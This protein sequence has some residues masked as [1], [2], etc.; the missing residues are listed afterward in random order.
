M[1][2]DIRSLFIK[3]IHKMQKTSPKVGWFF[4]AEIF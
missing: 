3:K 4:C 1:T 2:E